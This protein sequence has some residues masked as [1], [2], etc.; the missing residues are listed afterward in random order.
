MKTNILICALV[1]FGSH[2]S[3]QQ[4]W[5][6][7]I[8]NL[9]GNQCGAICSLNKD[10]VCVMSD[11]GMFLKTPDG[12]SSW[13]EHNTGINRSFFD[14]AF[15]SSNTGYASGSSGIILKT[16]DRGTTWIPLSTGTNKDLFSVCIKSPE[17]IWAVGD[18][19]V[20]LHSADGGCSW[21]KNNTLTGNR[22]NSICFQDSNTGFIAGNNG[23]LL[24]T[25]NGGTTWSPVNIATTKDLFSLS[26]TN[27]YTYLLAGG[28][29]NYYYSSDELFKTADNIT[30]TSNYM[31]PSIPGLSRLIFQNDSLGFTMASNCTTN[32]ECMII[33]TKSSDYGQNWYTSFNNWNPPSLV[34]IAHGDISFATDSIGYALCGNNILKTTDQGTFVSIK[35]LNQ[36][37]GF[38]IFPNPSASDAVSV[39]L[40]GDLQGLSVEISD[41]QGMILVKKDNLERLNALDIS[42]IHPGVYFVRLMKENRII[43]VDKLL[44]LS[45][46]Q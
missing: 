15:S 17:N 27:N 18:S 9:T 30:W 35:E 12:G 10:T 24:E 34:G 39:E 13:T 38:K 29:I 5:Q 28:V 33:M 3:A 7:E 22:L 41:M 31:G 44:R 1:A 42:Q 20:I 6:Y 2:L 11:G 45:P 19:G 46:G 4:G 43:G 37:P 16:F 21:T 25:V 8:S 36:H 14:L 26:A 23:T 40:T 32:G